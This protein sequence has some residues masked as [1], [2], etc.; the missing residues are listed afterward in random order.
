MTSKNTTERER[1]Y[2]ETKDA[3]RV[4]L[5]GPGWLQVGKRHEEQMGK[6]GAEVCAIDVA[7]VFVTCVV[8]VTALRA[9]SLH[10]ACARNVGS[11]NR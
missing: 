11:P 4:N 3:R 2:P 5:G 1:A 7:L 9:V 6:G 10:S 8:D